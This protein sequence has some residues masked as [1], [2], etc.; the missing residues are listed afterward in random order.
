MVD[1]FIIFKRLLVSVYPQVTRN[2]CSGKNSDTGWEVDGKNGNKILHLSTSN[3]VRWSPVF[4]EQ[5]NCDFFF[6]FYQLLVI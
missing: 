1:I 2:V 3:G 4:V 5:I 6:L